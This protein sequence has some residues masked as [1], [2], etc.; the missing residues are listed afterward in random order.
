MSRWTPLFSKT[1][2]A[3]GRERFSRVRVHPCGSVTLGSNV[4]ATVAVALALAGVG[5][6]TG[7]GGDVQSRMAEVRALQDVGQFTASIDELREILVIAP[8][9]PE[10][11]YRLGVALVQTGERSRAIWSLQK[12]SESAE[13]S[14]PAG[15]LLATVHLANR[16]FDEALRVIDRVLEI[17]PERIAAL[18]LRAK[19]NIGAKNFKAALID[20]EHLV[21]LYPD[22][23]ASSALLATALVD[24]GKFEEAEA[25][26]DRLK[27]LAANSGDLDLEARGCL[28]PAVFAQDQL[29]DYDKA[30]RYYEDCLT[31]FP[32]KGFVITQTTEFFDQIGRPDRSTEIFRTAIE[33]SPE[34]LGL[35]AGL[36]TRLQTRGELEEAEAVLVEAAET[37][38]SAQAWNALASFYRTTDQTQKALDSIDKVIEISGTRDIL[39][40]QKAD[41][42][43]DMGELD[44]A[45]ALAA[46]LAEPT[47]ATLIRGRILRARG[48]PKGALEAFDKGIRSWP[49]NAAARYLAGVAARD[50]GDFDRA[51]SELREAIRVDKTA[52]DASIVLARLYYDR[53][54]Y[55]KALTFANSFIKNRASSDQ[56]Y[57]ALTIASR[58]LVAQKN[59]NQ[60]R[61]SVSLIQEMPGRE[62]EAAI[63]SAYID[64][65]QHGPAAAI[66]S[67]EKSGVD[68]NTADNEEVL[69][70]LADGFLALGRLDEALARIDSGLA[71][72]PEAASLYELR[73]T[74]LARMDRRQDAKDA[75]DQAIAL[76]PEYAAAYGGLATLRAIEGDTD[77]AIELFDR[78]AEL[79][80][81]NVDYLYSAS[82]LNMALGNL[83]ESERR[84]R[85]IVRQSVSHAGSRNDLAWLLTEKREE[86]DFALD[87]AEE[88]RRLAPTSNNLDTLGWVHLQRG[89]AESAVMVLERA[90]ELDPNS[91]SIRYHLALALSEAGHD[92]RAREMLQSALDAGAFP[93]FEEARQK[94]EQYGQL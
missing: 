5:T 82:Q 12:A 32:N 81:G 1:P 10:A 73:A 39:R 43:V 46:E 62:R 44:R 86:L 20:A 76:D 15:S 56:N 49:N 53:G 61:K 25:A 90:A 35:R 83:E 33:E 58:S 24:A 38:G 23:Y 77:K 27:T 8:D 6:S 55:P 91:P 16:D 60:A 52:T 74:V 79:D 69:R 42:L 4:L 84:L 40:F 30:T 26:H 13:Y 2:G 71:H 9:L 88:A 66:A 65:H 94:L 29:Q 19:A 89:E 14:I 93:E 3:S 51:V 18:Q 17:D 34:N 37:F 75:F 21:E 57:V 11:S 70:L 31:K 59:F 80:P 85:S 45:E 22:D 67:L 63:E 72:R 41:L 36:A 78:A 64:R 7:C 92:A 54:E 87:L 48:D 28:A 47:Y 50:I 68:P